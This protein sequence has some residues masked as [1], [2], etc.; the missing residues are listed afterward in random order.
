MR[1]EQILGPVA[2]ELAAVEEGV[3][4]WAAIDMPAAPGAIGF[5]ERQ[6]TGES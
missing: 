4:S 1:L 2:A 6:K 5:E 3:S